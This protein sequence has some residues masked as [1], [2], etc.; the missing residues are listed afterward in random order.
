MTQ[1]DHVHTVTVSLL[2]HASTPCNERG[3]LC[4]AGC[5]TGLS[6]AGLRDLERALER[7]DFPRWSL[8]L[9]SPLKRAR[10]TA[11]A[12]SGG[13]TT[14]QR[15]DPRL[16]EIN[17]GTWEGMAAAAL[18]ADPR[19]CAFRTDPAVYSPPDGESID[20][21]ARRASASLREL[22][23]SGSPSD[24]PVLVVSHKTTLRVLLCSLLGFPLSEYRHRF[25]FPPLHHALVE[26]RPGGARLVFHPQPLGSV[27]SHDHLKERE[28]A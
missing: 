28:R 24:D 9:S 16:A 6:P 19:F 18:E 15:L 21:V 11:A 22:A 26:L 12:L 10:E 7:P 2:R 8:V 17:Y 23:L 13:K 20:E 14:P 25:D 3:L 1:R 5:D 4:G 27:E